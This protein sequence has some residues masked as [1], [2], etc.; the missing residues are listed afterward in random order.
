MIWT[1]LKRVILPLLVMIVVLAHIGRKTFHVELIIPAPPEQIWAVLM[2]TQAYGEWKPVFTQVDGS[3]QQG[4]TV[5][6]TVVDPNGNVL[7]IKASVDSL[8]AN[9]ELRQSGGLFGFL[10]FDHQWL[11]EPV[12]EGTKVT[13]LEFDQGLYMWF[14]DSSWIEPSYTKVSEA[15]RDRVAAKSN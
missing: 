12:D 2:D 13:Q 1:I 6:N 3:Y 8:V 7:N 9:R 14:W 4:G 11:L 10:T 5:R 15:L